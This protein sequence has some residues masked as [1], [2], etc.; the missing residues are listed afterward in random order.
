MSRLAAAACARRPPPSARR[1]RIVARA[2]VGDVLKRG[3]A[4]CFCIAPPPGRSRP[5]RRAA[6]AAACRLRRS[7][8]VTPPARVQKP[9]PGANILARDAAPGADVAVRVICG[10]AA[11]ATPICGAGRMQRRL[12]RAHVGALLDQLRRQADRQVLRQFQRR[13]FECLGRLL[14]RETAGQRGQQVALLRQLLLQRRQ[15]R[16]PGPARPPA[17]RHRPGDLAQR[18]A[19]L[20]NMSSASLLDLD[21]FLGR[22]DLAAQRASCTPPATTLEVRVR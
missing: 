8:A 6:C 2:S 21:D 18:H 3:D 15:G 19:G 5:R 7:A 9:L 4:P 20:R 17:P 10:S 14:A 12:G 11:T 13:E 22:G 1:R 16:S